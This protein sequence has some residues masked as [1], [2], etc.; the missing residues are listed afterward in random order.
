LALTGLVLLAGVVPP[1][2][3]Q[4]Y[5]VRTY[6]ENEGLPSSEPTSLAQTADGRLWVSARGGIASYDGIAWEL[7]GQSE[8]LVRPDG[9]GLQT[10]ADGRLF[11]WR[12]TSPVSLVRLAGES[13]VPVLLPPDLE[14]PIIAFAVDESGRQIALYEQSGILH[15]RRGPGW[16]RIQAPR[17]VDGRASVSFVRSSLFTAT[18]A[19]VLQL[20]EDGDVLRPVTIGPTGAILAIAADPERYGLWVVGRDAFGHMEIRTGTWREAGTVPLG[21]PPGHATA[22]SRGRLLFGN[23][24]D[25]Y[26]YDP[27]EGLLRLGRDEGL[28]SEGITGACLDR[29]GCL[30]I[31]CPRGL[32]KLVHRRFENWSR[33]HGLAEDEVTAILLRPGRVPV[34]GHHGAVT[35][36]EDPPRVVRFAEARVPARVL[37]LAEDPDGSVWIAAIEAGLARLD[38]SGRTVEWMDAPGSGFPVTTVLVDEDASLR[39]GV[40][41][42]LYRGRP[43]AWSPWILS[44]GVTA[45]VRR[46]EDLPDGV[47]AISTGAGF[48]VLRGGE[49]RTFVGSGLL[50][51]V[52]DVHPRRAGG[53]WV[54]TKAGLARTEAD[55]IVVS[56][57]P[58]V[59]RPVYFLVEGPDRRLWIGTDSGVV[60][61]NPSSGQAESFSVADGLIGRETNRAA[62]SVDAEGRVWIGTDQGLSVYRPTADSGPSA[63][64]ILDLGAPQ[65]GGAPIDPDR[66]GRLRTPTLGVTFPFRAISFVDE[67]RVE[68]RWILDGLTTDWS[69]SVKAQETR[70]Q[71]HH[72][73]PGRYR[74]RLQARAAGG[75]WGSPEATPWV[76]VLAPLHRRWWFE[77]GAV[78][79]AVLGAGLFVS[80]LSARRMSRRLERTVAQRT[81]ELREE[82]ERLRITLHGSSDGI[83]AI[84]ADHRVE[85]SNPAA[86]R[87]FGIP[88][89]QLAGRSVEEFLP[90]GS[91]DALEGLIG[92][93]LEISRTRPDGTVAR[94]EWSAAP[95]RGEA[96]APS[97]WVV[98]FRDVTERHRREVE[99]ARSERLLSVGLLAAGIAHDFN[100]LLMV[101]LGNLSLLELDDQL[102]PDSRASVSEAK[103]ASLRARSLTERLLTFAAGG[104]PVRSSVPLVSLVREALAR[105]VPPPGITVREEYAAD[106]PPLF[107]D[108]GQM[109][110]AIA[111]VLA[112]ALEAM[113]GDGIL[114]VSARRRVGP[115]S[116]PWVEL[117]IDDDGAGI[118]PGDLPHVFEPFFSRRDKRSGLGLAAVHSIVTQHGGRVEITP[119]SVRGTR[120][121]IELPAGAS[122]SEEAARPGPQEE[123]RVLVL[124]DEDEVRLALGSMVERLGHRVEAVAEGEGAVKAFREALETGDPFHVVLLDV[125][126]D[127][128]L[129]GVGAGRRILGL[130]PSARIVVVSGYTGDP[131]ISDPSGHGFHSAL[132]KP[133]AVE[134]LDRAIRGAAF[135]GTR[136]PE[137]RNP[138]SGTP[139]GG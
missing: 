117:S 101:I 4:S 37:D 131:A 44:S 112:N 73:G 100:N 129:D 20:D 105:A 1:A 107:L 17:P 33:A 36:L 111:N 108:E 125:E 22:D 109:V 114:Q 67:D 58:M 94:L 78:L 30:W 70:I 18:A 41:S 79:F 90:D 84:D 47:R 59:S 27:A 106:L 15:I 8:E 119:R 118:A 122:A 62:A 3:A 42:R 123:L 77:A 2:C 116:E 97:G 34:L 138:Q 89:A 6:T 75:A 83:L 86:E 135:G 53:Y 87:L 95:L 127:E 13:F 115:D 21:F 61:W 132:R 60:A 69:E 43:G 40:D 35:L 46:I 126:I 104:A 63:S 99:A 11:A 26:L 81:K 12:G 103:A 88:D 39:L 56:E 130:D 7:R 52:Y 120:V 76:T 29:E 14:P 64:P 9:W 92:E 23:R 85:L 102:T 65:A 32:S 57:R 66:R 16:I 48:V 10:T 96:D 80:W 54:G 121:R 68:V 113:E 49:V 139:G 128:G 124:D 25:A 50:N 31:S 24:D 134:D 5:L 28:V 133:F 110:R 19:G 74:L 55:S 45:Y 72:L 98:V 136:G 137:F 51:S 91:A 82:K 93:S 71:F 38:P